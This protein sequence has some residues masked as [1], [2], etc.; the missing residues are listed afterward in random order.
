M[1]LVPYAAVTLSLGIAVSCSE[2]PREVTLIARGMTFVLADELDVPNP[3]IVLAAGQRVR[4]VLRNEAPGLLHDFRIP[5]WRVQ[6]TQIRAGETAEVTFTVPNQPGRYEYLCRPH[7][8]LMKG[9][10]EVTP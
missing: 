4:L 9:V 7:A 2:S 8:E 3:V 6:L 1:R 10:V 5:A